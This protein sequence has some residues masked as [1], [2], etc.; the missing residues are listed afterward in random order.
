MRILLDSNA[1][2][3]FMRGNHRLREIVQ[4]AEE[5]LMSAVVLGEQLYGFRQGRRF[6]Q[7]FAQAP[8]GEVLAEIRR[9]LLQGNGST[10]SKGPSHS[11]QRR[12]DR[13]SCHGDRC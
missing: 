12:M 8:A 11:N 9:S 1:Y 10:T 2:S 7:N 3:E 4:G 13:S 6:E 5:I